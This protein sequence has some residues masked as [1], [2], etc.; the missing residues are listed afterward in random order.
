[1]KRLW[2]SLICVTSGSLTAQINP[3]APT[4]QWHSIGFSSSSVVPDPGSDQQ[5][6]SAEGDVVG[7]ASQPAFYSAFDNA[8]TLSTADGTL[9]FRVR[10]GA[11]KSPAGYSGAA[12]VGI[13]AN[14]DGKLDFFLG[15]NNSG[16]SAQI[17]IWSAGT[18]AN[19]SPNTTTLA[20]TAAFSFAETSLNYS[21]QQ[22]TAASDPSAVNYDLDGHGD[23]DYFVSF[24]VPFS[25]VVAEATSLG[26]S[27]DEHTPVYYVFA[28][29][30]QANSLNQD[31]GGVNGGVNSSSSWSSLGA[32][33]DTTSPNTVVPEPQTWCLITAA[34]AL[35]VIRNRYSQI[36]KQRNGSA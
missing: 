4:T 10:V 5:T 23:P 28:T 17:G 18:G 30:T 29:A 31:I 3:A 11:D 34:A 25:N 15:V 12:F 8:G 19:T 1:M 22:V 27:L 2:L 26:L 35:F 21:W 9:A 13:D 33:S 20:N 14:R 16:S 32:L 36:R 24:T 7:S 6:G